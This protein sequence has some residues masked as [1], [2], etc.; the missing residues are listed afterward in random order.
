MM[1]TDVADF[2]VVNALTTGWF[3]ARAESVATD[4]PSFTS[5]EP[6]YRPTAFTTRRA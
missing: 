1:T 4:M 6:K 2:T 3:I 5:W